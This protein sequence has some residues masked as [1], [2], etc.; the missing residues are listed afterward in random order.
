MRDPALIQVT[1]P[2]APFA[3]VFRARLN[4]SG[5][6]LQSQAGHLR[7]MADLSRWLVEH[8]LNGSGL[9]PEVVAGFMLDR[10]AGPVF[11]CDDR[12]H[13]V[14]QTHERLGRIALAAL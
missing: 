2:L 13:R 14:S 1:G 7:L 8:R 12:W 3:E 9:S 5:Y 10:R 11:D 6:A 4:R